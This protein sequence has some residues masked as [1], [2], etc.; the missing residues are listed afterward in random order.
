[1]LLEEL[2]AG[3]PRALSTR[4]DEAAEIIGAAVGM[5]ASQFFQVVVLPQGRFA[6]F[7]QAPA[8]QRQDLLQKLFGTERFADVEAALKRRRTCCGPSSTCC[9][10]PAGRGC[11]ARPRVAVV[12]RHRA[13]RPGA[14][15]GAGPAGALAAGAEAA[16][17]A[18]E[19]ARGR[20][21]TRTAVEAARGWP[22][23]RSEGLAAGASERRGR[24]RSAAQGVRARLWRLGPRRRFPLMLRDFWRSGCSARVSGRRHRPCR[25]L[26]PWPG[27][28]PRSSGRRSTAWPSSYRAGRRAGPRRGEQ[29]LTGRPL[30][31]RQPSSAMWRRRPSW[32][33]CVPAAGGW[34][35]PSPRTRWPSPDCLGGGSA[36]TARERAARSPSCRLRRRWRSR[37]RRS[38]RAPSGCPRRP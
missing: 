17:A 6:A 26:A 21:E 38:C 9:P 3:A 24:W 28:P 30:P 20:G 29:A 4:I 13:R 25:A 36:A 22:S 37:L 31:C 12:A 23:C 16:E 19:R 15:L 34:R 27:S 8:A 10:R 5:T 2:G 33:S 11:A 35:R 18:A 1:M 7:L 32:S 14:R